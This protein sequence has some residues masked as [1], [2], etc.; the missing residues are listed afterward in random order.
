MQKD[1]LTAGHDHVLLVLRRDRMP[2]QREPAAG[3]QERGMARGELA[4]GFGAVAVDQHVGELLTDARL[5]VPGRIE[6]PLLLLVLVLGR[7]LRLAGLLELRVGLF[8]VVVVDVDFC[9]AQPAAGAPVENSM[10]T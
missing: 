10:I 6:I 7:V 2:L 5:V 3:M 8:V 4:L 1:L 9:G